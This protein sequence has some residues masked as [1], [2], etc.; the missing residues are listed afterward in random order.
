MNERLDA[1][2]YPVRETKI[3]FHSNDNVEVAAVL[4]PLSVEANDLDAVA[5]DLC[6]DARG[7]P[8]PPAICQRAGVG[9][10]C[11]APSS[12]AR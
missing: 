7:Q 6:Q 10:N 4:V 5:A 2:S 1:A 9:A 11:A 3:V 8:T 12:A